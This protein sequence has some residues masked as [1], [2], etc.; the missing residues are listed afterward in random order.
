MCLCVGTDLLNMDHAD[1]V[2]DHWLDTFRDHAKEI[3]ARGHK[4]SARQAPLD[5]EVVAKAFAGSNDKFD[6]TGEVRFFL[7]VCIL[8][9]TSLPMS[10][11]TAL[12]S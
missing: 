11:M 4:L 9:A 3:H 1:F 6:V 10:A 12:Y 7:F 8:F 5:M 2:G